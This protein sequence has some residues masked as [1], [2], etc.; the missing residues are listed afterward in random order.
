MH[1][2][3][4]ICTKYGAVGE[5]IVDVLDIVMGPVVFFGHPVHGVYNTQITLW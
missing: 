3:R 1:E 2:L 4:I 5:E